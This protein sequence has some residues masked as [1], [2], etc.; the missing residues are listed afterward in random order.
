MRKIISV[1]NVGH[2]LFFQR[3]GRLVKLQEQGSFHLTSHRMR[4]VV[5]V[6]ERS[7]VHNFE[8]R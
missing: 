1:T 7:Q 2:R 3:N 8:F 5:K 4:S 6:I